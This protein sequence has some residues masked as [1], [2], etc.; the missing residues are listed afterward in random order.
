MILINNFM[1]SIPNPMTLMIIHSQNSFLIKKKKE[2]QLQQ[3]LQSVFVK[4]SLNVDEI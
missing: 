1:A 2:Q 3:N 4:V